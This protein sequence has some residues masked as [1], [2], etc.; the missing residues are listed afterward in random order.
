[1]CII[2]E[3]T[4]AEGLEKSLA[5]YLQIFIFFIYFIFFVSRYLKGEHGVDR[6]EN[7]GMESR[8]G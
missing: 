4:I 1:M 8:W 2:V 6:A 3:E 7:R 5:Y